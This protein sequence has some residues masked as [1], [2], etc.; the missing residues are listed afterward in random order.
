MGTITSP[1]TLSNEPAPPNVDPG[2]PTE[3][4]EIKVLICAISFIPY[5]ALSEPL[6][7]L[8]R[9]AK[10]SDAHGTHR[11]TSHPPCML[12]IWNGISRAGEIIQQVQRFWE[13]GKR[14]KERN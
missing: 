13:T 5:S 7:A 3:D 1:R 12:S 11:R 8:S 2:K 4:V 14:G 9:A 10:Q 6:M